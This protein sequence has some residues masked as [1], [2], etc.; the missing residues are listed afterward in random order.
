MALFSAAL[1]LAGSI[2]GANKAAKSQA[3]SLAQQQY[4]FNRNRELQDANMAIGLD[5][6]RLQQEE[7]QYQRAME[8]IN[9]RKTGDE[10]R[11]QLSE[12]ENYQEQLLSERRDV[13]ER[14]LLADK[15]AARQSQFELEQYL[16]NRDLAQE[17]RD[18]A[19]AALREAQAI[20]S[21]ERDEDKRRL[22]EDRAKSDI[23]REFVVDQYQQAQNTYS[24]ERE[25]QNQFRD[26]LMSRIDS[27]QANSQDFANAMGMPMEVDPMT[28]GDVDAEYQ[29][30]ADEYMSDV[31]RAAQ[32][33]AS[34]A[35]TTLVRRGM[36]DGTLADDTRA[37]LTRQVAD[38][39][40]KAR[41]AAYDDA[42][43]YISGRQA[44]NSADRNAQIERRKYLVGENTGLEGMAMNGML[45]L[46]GVASTTGQYNLLN[47]IPTSIYDRDVS[48]AN[49]YQAP[50]AIGTGIYDQMNVG[51]QLAGYLNNP[52][53]A[54]TGYAN[55]QSG[56]YNPMS[57]NF[58]NAANSFSNASSM[59]NQMI[60][61]AQNNYA[62]AQTQAAN[63]GTGLADSF[64]TFS[65]ELGSWW[66]NRNKEAGD[67]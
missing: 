17:E 64:A 41:R 49:D 51:S 47:A 44:M 19:M 55:I 58:G 32:G 63:A 33:M 29:I 40:T 60:S 18:E 61:T 12:Y 30:R 57:M 42:S 11:Y 38:Q 59:G 16:Q 39:Y 34:S 13:I 21:G 54:S 10:R 8:R 65:N 24:A 15:E 35:E 6:R 56:I 25:E 14:Q 27:V 67:D 48:S 50:I 22:L 46:P 9:R 52:S 62:N 66:K 20:A 23:E 45:Q 26:M 37:Q 5:D 53:A 3:A 36:S 43:R 4:E 31:D 2:Y 1:G 28:Q 7:N